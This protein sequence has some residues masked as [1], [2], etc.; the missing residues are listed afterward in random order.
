MRPWDPGMGIIP[1]LIK[2][3][4]TNKNIGM[5]FLCKT[6]DSVRKLVYHDNAIRH[7]VMY[8]MRRRLLFMRQDSHSVLFL[9]SI[10][11]VW[12]N[13]STGS[14]Y[15]YEFQQSLQ[16][17]EAR[18][19]HPLE[20]PGVPTGQQQCCLYSPTLMLATRTGQGDKTMSRH[21]PSVNTRQVH[22][23]RRNRRKQG[24]QEKIMTNSDV[25]YLLFYWLIFFIFWSKIQQNGSL[26]NTVKSQI[27]IG[28]CR[29]EK[30]TY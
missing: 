6:V 12:K 29:E 5:P 26:I 4:K 16:S 8:K 15:F 2:R 9:G 30:L 24:F 17:K 20:T 19:A 18:V 14:P 3:G 21:G 13:T 1:A 23:S 28:A 25:H 11:S 10:L 27:R 22:L 7:F